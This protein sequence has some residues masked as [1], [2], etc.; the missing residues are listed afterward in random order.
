M[1]PVNLE[2]ANKKYGTNYTKDELYLEEHDPEKGKPE[3]FCVHVT[4]LH[5]GKK[6]EAGKKSYNPD[7]CMLRTLDYIKNLKE[8]SKIEHRSRNFATFAILDTGDMLDGMGIYPTQAAG[9]TALPNLNHQ[10]EGVI[11]YFYRPLIKFGLENFPRVLICKVPGNHG[12]LGKFQSEG[13][14]LDCMVTTTL[15]IAFSGHENVKIVGN[16]EMQRSFDVDGHRILLFHGD[17]KNIR[18]YHG[19][20]WY[21]INKSTLGWSFLDD[22]DFELACMG[23]FHQCFDMPIQMSKGKMVMMSGTM[24]TADDFSIKNYQSDGDHRRWCF[25]LHPDRKGTTFQYKVDLVKES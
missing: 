2:L 1:S 20:P 6:T 15:R 7:V 8:L 12:R 24:V 3:T 10:I 18:S 16:D 14:N 23:H 5:Y 21:T 4:D 9:H 13:S 11:E 17:G 19:L 22:L 25:G